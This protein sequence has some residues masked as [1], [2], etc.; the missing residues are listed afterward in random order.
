MNELM[1]IIDLAE[2]EIA[3]RGSDYRYTDEPLFQQHGR[4]VNVLFDYTEKADLS[5]WEVSS[6]SRLD[7]KT[8]FRPGC[9]V[10]SI[11]LNYTEMGWFMQK[12]HNGSDSSDIISVLRSDG[13]ADISPLASRY[14]RVVQDRQDGGSTWGEAHWDGLQ[15][16]LMSASSRINATPGEWEYLES[17]FGARRPAEEKES[18]AA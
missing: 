15:E 7:G 8:N 17:I 14:L 6:P 4:C 18:S 12:G 13:L 11:F 10:G 5:I 3:K 2:A 16:V 9:L 1:E